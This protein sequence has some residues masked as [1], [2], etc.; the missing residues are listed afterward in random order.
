MGLPYIGETLSYVKNLAN[1]KPDKFISDRQVKHGK[2]VFKTSLFGETMVFLCGPEG[3]K[4]IFANEEKYLRVWWPR[5]VDKVFQKSDN[6]SSQDSSSR[7]RKNMIPFLKAD[8]LRTYV[9]IMDSVM[10]KQVNMDWSSDSVKGSALIK[11][12]TFTLACRVFFSIEDPLELE[13]LSKP[14]AAV[15]NGIVTIPLNFP[16]TLF[17]AAIEG[18]KTIKKALEV[19]IKQRRIDIAEK[20]ATLTQDVLSLML[21]EADDENEMSNTD[22]ASDFVGILVASYDS[23][24]TTLTFTMKHLAEHPA[25]YDQVLKGNYEETFN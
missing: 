1:G 16:G 7:V 4:F 23:T 8:L 13:K 18:S 9:P 12:F 17:R 10:K 5:S 24:N 14:F 19:I 2:K 21:S 20:R 11:K 3:N 22:I 25:I 15:A 6:E